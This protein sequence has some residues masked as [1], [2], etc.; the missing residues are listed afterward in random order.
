[1]VLLSAL[2]TITGKF[3]IVLFNPISSSLPYGTPQIEGYW[4]GDASDA[5]WSDF[6]NTIFIF[7][8]FDDTLR[9][10]PQNRTDG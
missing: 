1:M 5:F 6:E 9:W 4:W 2:F 3:N 7:R 8:S 10:I